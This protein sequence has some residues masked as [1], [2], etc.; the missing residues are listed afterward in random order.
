MNERLQH[1]GLHQHRITV[2]KLTLLEELFW[3]KFASMSHGC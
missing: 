1:I 3:L 2:H